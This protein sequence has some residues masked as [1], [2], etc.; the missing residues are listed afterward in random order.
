MD[1]GEGSRKGKGWEGRPR[2]EAG[3]GCMS[4]VLDQDLGKPESFVGQKGGNRIGGE[5]E[6]G[7][8]RGRSR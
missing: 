3:G 4:H 2:N 8:R 1:Q 6:G 7:G 5:R